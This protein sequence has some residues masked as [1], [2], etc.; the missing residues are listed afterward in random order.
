MRLEIENIPIIKYP[1]IQTEIIN[2]LKK[3]G[4]ENIDI[5]Q[6]K[7]GEKTIGFMIIQVEG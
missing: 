1:R 5:L 6:Q 3:N 2:I 7:E 4:I